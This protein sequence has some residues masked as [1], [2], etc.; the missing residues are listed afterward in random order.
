M[1]FDYASIAVLA[2]ELLAEFGQPL[3]ITT[4]V[5]GEYDPAT[6]LTSFSATSHEGY[7]AVLDYGLHQSGMGAGGDSLIQHGDKQLLL[8]PNVIT[9]PLVDD[10]VTIG[11]LGYTIKNIKT[12]APSGVPVLY[13]CNVRT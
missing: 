8:S 5:T 7:G 10:I 12:V 13:D 6:G 4:H 1:S 9:P 11:Q 3:T 2:D